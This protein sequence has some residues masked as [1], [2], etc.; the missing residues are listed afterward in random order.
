MLEH[1]TPLEKPVQATLHLPGS[2]S[3]TN[4]VLIMADLCSEISQVSNALHSDDTQTCREALK[5]MTT[6]AVIDCQDA[7]TVA[8]F[9]VPVCA[10]K[11]G[12]YVFRGSPRLC[13]RPMG[14]LLRSLEQQGA[15]F[16]WLANPYCLPFV[17]T[18]HG[19]KGGFISVN[20]EDSSQFLSGLL[21][22][23]PLFQQ[24][25]ILQSSD[26]LMTLPYVQM[27]LHL[28]RAFGIHPVILDASRVLIMPTRY[29]AASITI[30][31]DA[32]TASYFFAAAALSGG[33]VKIM[34]LTSDSLQGDLKFLTCLEA[35]GC[36]IQSKSDSIEVV[37]PK[38]LQA[39]G[40]VNMK[41]FS[42]TFMTL[43]VIAPFLPTPTTLYGLSH[44]RLQES[45]RLEAMAEGLTRVGIKTHTTQDSLTIFPGN[46]VGALIRS[47]QDHRIA[48][49][50][51]MLGL[52]I[53]GMIIDDASC[54][55]KTCPSFFDRVSSLN[56]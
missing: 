38:T 9:L 34:H 40:E 33:R 14:V 53:P 37:G 13:E 42:D 50:F 15:S 6:S 41:G 30:E 48:M 26:A 12:R 21:I 31:P 8:R 55:S 52:R 1:I 5:Q 56:N 51:A 29:Q 19:L 23:A 36:R 25:V 11:G 2:K 49:S 35:M 3:I 7:G 4:R 16:E 18:S 44:T 47:H 46:P 10:A 24:E 22:A 28:M 45:D 27:T 20:V 32:S 39:L 54:V 17:M 43:A